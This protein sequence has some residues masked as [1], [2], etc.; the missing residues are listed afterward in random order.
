[1]GKRQ[2]LIALNI[3]INFSFNFTEELLGLKHV[4]DM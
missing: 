3:S 4:N 2:K 1:M